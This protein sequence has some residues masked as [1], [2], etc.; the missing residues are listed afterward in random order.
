MK[1]SLLF[2]GFAILFS[3]CVATAAQ[4]QATR[5]WVSGV[6]D[7]ANP[8]SRTAPCKTFAGA[9]SKTAAGG[10][11]DA[12]DP[13]GFGTLTITKAI[14]I[15]GGGGQIS[16]ALAAGTPGFTISAGAGDNVVL[17]NLRIQGIGQTGSPGTYGINF[18]SG[19]SLT[20]ENDTID[21]FSQ[22]GVNFQPAVHA[23]LTVSNCTI[24]YNQ[25]GGIAVSTTSGKNKATI[26]NSRL[27]NNSNVT[28]TSGTPTTGYGLFV[29]ANSIATISYSQIARNGDA[30]LLANGTAFIYALD[31][32]I[33]NNLSNGVHALNGGS[34][35]LSNNLITQNH[36]YGLLFES[37]GTI[38]SAGNNFVLGNGT[39]GS[40]SSTLPPK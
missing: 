4:A 1:R 22:I 8:C 34:I 9:I 36:L 30:G 6:G 13:G 2:F 40:P 18:N 3:L 14:T 37:G 19:F 28:P 35:G 21:G 17:R 31:S 16:S 15:D 33:S 32:D 27:F 7:D 11:I 23:A 20:L 38:V 29:G 10:E 5:T 12:L 39:D 25:M 26:S 24:E